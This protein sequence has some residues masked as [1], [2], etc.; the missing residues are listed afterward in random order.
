DWGLPDLPRTMPSRHTVIGIAER[1]SSS[2]AARHGRQCWR[3]RAPGRGELHPGRDGVV[4]SAGGAGAVAGRRGPQVAGVRAGAWGARQ[5]DE[6]G[7]G[8]A[9]EAAVAARSRGLQVE[10][11]AAGGHEPAGAASTA[12]T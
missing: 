10:A 7:C 5:V 8:S 9:L 6:R 3:A 12:A 11:R 4:R 1:L 2:T